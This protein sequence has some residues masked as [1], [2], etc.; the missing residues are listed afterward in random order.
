[1]DPGLAEAQLRAMVA[2]DNAPCL[3]DGQIWM[4]VQLAAD[5]DLNAAAAEGWRWKAAA[6]AG[7]YGFS[8][9]GQR[10]DRDQM[11]AMCLAMVGHYARRR[12]GSTRVRGSVAA[13]AEN[14]ASC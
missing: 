7:E 12:S 13:A 6:V 11:H 10:F 4:L 1:M 5:S 14:V 8:I 3:D 9:D 2:A